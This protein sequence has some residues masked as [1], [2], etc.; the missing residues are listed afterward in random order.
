MGPEACDGPYVQSV[1]SARAI[2]LSVS[3]SVSE[4]CV[5]A[6]QCRAT[7]SDP[8]TGVG[9][10]SGVDS[11]VGVDDVIIHKLAFRCCNGLQRLSQQHT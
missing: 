11:G 1:H 6:N 7:D 3:P 9:V 8:P 5:Y 2:S 4:Q 10:D